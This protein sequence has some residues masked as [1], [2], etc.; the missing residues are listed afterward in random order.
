MK[1]ITA[2]RKQS[3]IFLVTDEVAKKFEDGAL[4]YDE[5]WEQ[6]GMVTPDPLVYASTEEADLDA[7]IDIKEVFKNYVDK[8]GKHT[9]AVITDIALTEKGG[10]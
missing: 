2:T 5:L 6:M 8:N 7:I 10:K 4:R 1:A 3:L 9:Q